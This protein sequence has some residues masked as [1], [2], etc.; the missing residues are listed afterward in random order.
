MAKF[1]AE[2]GEKSSR[3]QPL[4]DSGAERLRLIFDLHPSDMQ[5]SIFLTS[6]RSIYASG[7]RK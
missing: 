7:G 4:Q 3:V 2:G 5:Y 1:H 6:I